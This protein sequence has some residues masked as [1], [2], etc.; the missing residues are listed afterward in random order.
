[1]AEVLGIST[2]A[3][4][5]WRERQRV[6]PSPP[7]PLGRPKVISREVRE[8]IR[9]CYRDHYGQWGPRT[10]ACWCRREGLRDWC[11]STVAAVIADL[12]DEPEVNSEPIRYEIT[13]PRVMWSEDGTGFK[14]K[15]RKKELLIAQDEHARFKVNTRLV[16]GPAREEDVVSY[17]E[18]AFE[19]HGPPLVIKHDGDAIFHGD[20]MREL[21]DRYEVLELTGPRAYPQYNGK[22]ERSIRDVKSYERALRRS[23]QRL[24]LRQRLAETIHDLNEERPRPVLGGRTAR[25]MFN[26]KNVELPDRRRFRKE[27]DR[28]EQRLL[29]TARSRSEQRSARRRAI[30]EVLLRYCLMK[31]SGDVSRNYEAIKRTN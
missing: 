4:Q 16:D 25:E 18:E 5:R 8:K 15:G 17:L 7:A 13:A 27:V 3:L 30:E 26:Q 31:E 1:V 24:S 9:Q 6:E 23:R 2:L 14:E 21:L 22:K 29:V 10:L 28:T 19:R 20:R 12:R 11:A